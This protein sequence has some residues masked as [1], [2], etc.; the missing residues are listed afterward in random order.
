MGPSNGAPFRL[1]GVVSVSV[2]FFPS[3]FP[4]IKLGLF[5]FCACDTL[6]VGMIN[7]MSYPL[8]WHS[9]MQHW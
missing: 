3:I 4:K 9:Q 5:F 8:N 1:K 2:V 6:A 7:L